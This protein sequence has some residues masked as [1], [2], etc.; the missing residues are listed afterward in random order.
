LCA[1]D[2]LRTV[3]RGSLLDCGRDIQP[4]LAA[5]NV[6]ATVRAR[7]AH[8]DTAILYRQVT[9]SLPMPARS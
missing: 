5:L 1:A 8:A 9:A 2:R 7:P 6:I 3:A 4:G